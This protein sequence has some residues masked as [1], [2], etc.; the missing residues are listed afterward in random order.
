MEWKI[1]HLP[2]I[3]STNDYAKQIS[4]VHTSP[5]FIYADYQTN[6]KGQQNNVWYSKPNENLLCS[7]LL[8]IYIPIYQNNYISRWIA[9]TI[10][11]L[12][13]K[14][15]IPHSSIKIKWPNDIIVQTNSSFKKISGILIENTIEQNHIKQ[16]IIGIGININQT[17]FYH[18][19][20]IATSIKLITQQTYRISEIIHLFIQI[21]NEFLPL[22]ELQQYNAINQKYLNY[23]YGWQHNFLFRYQNQ[24]YSG[25]IIQIHDDG[26]IS[27]Q[28]PSFTH[29]Y[30]HKQIQFI[31]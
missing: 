6:G 11:E 4:S 3:N 26:K 13:K 17:N 28:T 2:I 12:L 27:V 23:L 20:K 31:I 5:T 25:K 16:S 1:I 15:N 7:I 22:I 18:L 21:I 8:P 10:V 29:I 30:T 9:L 19:N 24:I 14:L